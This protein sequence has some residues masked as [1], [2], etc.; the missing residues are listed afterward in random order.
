MEPTIKEDDLIITKN[1]KEDEIKEQDVIVF[2]RGNT[3]ISHRVDKMTVDN[4]K[5]YYI[6]KGDSNFILDEQ[7]VQ[8]KDIEG[9]YVK[10][11][12]KIGKIMSVLKNEKI[13]IAFI[14][15]FL[16]INYFSCKKN[17]EKLIRQQQRRRY[18]GKHQ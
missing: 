10:R 18:E 14:I 16:V 8:Y 11:I 12:P 17:K 1:C 5:K 7:K 6:T 4:G 3:I 9:K 15:V 13:V 2:K